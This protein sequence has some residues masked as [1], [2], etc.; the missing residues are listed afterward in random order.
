MDRG[1][2]R[3]GSASD[4][5]GPVTRGGDDDGGR[6]D[7]AGADDA[8]VDWDQMLG[9]LGA[10]PVEDGWVTLEEAVSATGVSRSTIRSWYRTG[11]IPS[12][13]V[14]GVHGPQRIVPLEAVVDRAL[15]SP[16]SR[17]QLEQAGS[18]RAEVDE[19]RRRL[20]SIERHLGFR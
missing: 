19:L 10:Q 11:G 6:V 17:R 1:D 18:L 20:E 7:R 13:M 3:Q 8:G 9:E 12:R 2:G 5:G 4:G 14:A 16:R 15:G